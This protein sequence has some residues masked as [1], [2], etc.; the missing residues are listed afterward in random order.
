LNSVGVFAVEIYTNWVR[1][2]ELERWVLFLVIKKPHKCRAISG[3]GSSSQLQTLTYYG[4]TLLRYQAVDGIL[5]GN[6]N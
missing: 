3:E 1:K 4:Q 5:L 6:S 2:E